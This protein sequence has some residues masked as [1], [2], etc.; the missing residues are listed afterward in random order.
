MIAVIKEAEAV[1][2]PRLHRRLELGAEHGVWYQS[3]HSVR[4]I[5]SLQPMP[6]D[7]PTLFGDG[8]DQT[9]LNEDV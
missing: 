3:L 4:E 2:S 9:C 6:P 8:G 7:F 1:T 5:R